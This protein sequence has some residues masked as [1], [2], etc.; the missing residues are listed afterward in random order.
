MHPILFEFKT[1][2]F[3]NSVFPDTVTIY[4]YGTMIALGALLGFFY[5]AWQAKKQFNVPFDTTNE[6]VLAILISAI[7]GGKL[8]VIFED[9]S[10][11]LEN[12]KEIFRNFNQGFVFYGSLLF[13][14]PTMLIFFRIKKL[15]VL[16][17][18]DIMAVTTLIVHGTGRIGCFLAGCCY[19]KPHDGFFSIVFTDPACQAEP[20]NTPLHPTQLYSV[21]LLYGILAFL[22]FVKSKKSFPGQLF[23]LYLIIYSF[24]RIWIE[25]F[26]G[27]LSRGYVIGEVIS[28]SQFM[29][30]L[31][32]S[33]SVY[34]Y[35]KLKK[36]ATRKY[37]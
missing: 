30:L 3:L 32:F 7:I 35:I 24:G 27:D 11:Y 6:L 12:P 33:V 5:T 26:R 10:R 2:G 15:P 29:S 16:P 4:S 23:L 21:F 37:R 14:I 9:P 34:F 19:G 17:M 28:N 18:L 1:P 22:L 36:R 31:V 25:L 13:A 8:F 20:L